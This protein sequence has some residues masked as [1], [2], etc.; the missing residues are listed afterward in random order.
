MSVKSWMVGGLALMTVLGLTA[1][2][3]TPEKETSEKQEAHEEEHHGHEEG[4]GEAA[5]DLA[6]VEMKLPEDAHAGKET[7]IE[8][9][10][11]HDGKP[12]TDANEVKFELWKKGASKDEH[13]KIDANKGKDGVY[14]IQHTFA[15][16][17][18]YKVMYHVTAKGGHVMEPAETLTVKP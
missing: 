10:I 4:H 18:E 8:V 2:G 12:V 17:G 16:A 5:E 6:Q 14:S 9:K 3:T 1:C 11:T 13:E 7:E 15:E